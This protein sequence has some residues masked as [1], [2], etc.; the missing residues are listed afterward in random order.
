MDCSEKQKRRTMFEQQPESSSKEE[1]DQLI[2]N[3]TDQNRHDLD[4]D[5]EEKGFVS[6]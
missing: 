3:D 5:R 4:S 1:F 6:F 2:P